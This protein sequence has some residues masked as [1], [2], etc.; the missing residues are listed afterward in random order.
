M[1][2]GTLPPPSL[3]PQRAHRLVAVVVDRLLPQQHQLR[4]LARHDRRQQLGYGERLQRGGVGPRRGHVDRAVGAHR[5][6]RAQRVLGVGKGVG[7]WVGRWWREGGKKGCAGAC[8]CPGA[9]HVSRAPT[10]PHTCTGCGPSD[11]AT[12][13]PTSFCSFSRSASCRGARAGGGGRGWRWAWHGAVLALLAARSL[14][15]CCAPHTVPPSLPPTSS[16]ISQNGF[17]L[18]FTLARSTPLC[19]DGASR[20]LAA[21]A[22]A[23]ARAP[24]G[25]AARFATRALRLNPC[26]RSPR[27]RGPPHL[28]R[29]HAHARVV[30]HDALHRHQR[31][32]HRGARPGGRALAPHAGP[33]GG[34]GRW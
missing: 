12:T 29:L 11:T 20:A 2:G 18:I 6:R 17:I 28:V 14:P 32:L 8:T 21:A 31:A 27:P 22:S 5:Q 10:P 24:G 23:S 30:V 25:P 15:R 13:S 19:G 26:A 16:A 1:R 4:L 9:H 7:V 34:V 33:P 3:S